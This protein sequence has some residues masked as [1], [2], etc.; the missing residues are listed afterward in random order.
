MSTNC[1]NEVFGLVQKGENKMMN[2]R[3]ILVP[4]DFSANSNQVF[5]L[6]HCMAQHTHARLHL[7]HIIDPVYYEK[8]QNET[9]NLTFIHK[10][11]LENAKEELRK[12][13][14]ELPYSD[15]DIIEVLLEGIPH[16]EII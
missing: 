3:N 12:F 1:Q 2:M 11:R 5:E 14:V 6:G 13:K 15:V 4:I 8:Q 7:I 10:I 16:K 9:T